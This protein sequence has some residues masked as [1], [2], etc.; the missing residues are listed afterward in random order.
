MVKQ[1]NSGLIRLLG[2]DSGDYTLMVRAFSSRGIETNTLTYKIKIK[3]VF[4]KTSLFLGS[5]LFILIFV[6]GYWFIARKKQIENSYN[7]KIK[8]SQ[9][10]AKALRSQMNPHFIFNTLNSM[11]SIMI[12]KDEKEANKIF[13]AFSH[14]I[15]FTLDMSKSEYVLLKDEIKY[16]NSYLRIENSRLDDQLDISFYTDPDLDTAN[17]K[18]PC[19]LIQPLIENAIIHGLKPKKNN[20]K[21]KIFFEKLEHNIKVIVI[22]NGLGIKASKAMSHNIKTHKSWATNIM[23]ERINLLNSKK[24]NKISYS[25]ID[26]SKYSGD[27]D[28]GTKAILIMPLKS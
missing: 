6:L 27:E 4:Y 5:A 26:L 3:K 17:I 13:G 22:D 21:L 20:R 18:I 19:M 25:I 12:L 24:K 8:V 23:N 11:Q 16:L 28:T 14:L 2:L 10:E 15:R 1:Q 7:Q 9:L